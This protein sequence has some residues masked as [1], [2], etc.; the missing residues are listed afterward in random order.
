MLRFTIN[1]ETAQQDAKMEFMTFHHPLIRA[2]TYH[3][4]EHL[5]E[6]HPASHIKLRWNGIMP[7][8]Y[9]WF[10]FVIEISGARPMKDLSLVVL[11]ATP[12]TP[13]V[14]D[15]G[16]ALFNEMVLK[17]E[18]ISPP[19]RGRL[20]FDTAA[21]VVQADETLATRL[22]ARFE[23]MTKYNEALVSNRL[24]SLEESYN[25]TFTK[26][27]ERLERAI[28]ENKKTTYVKGLETSIRNLKATFEDKKAEIESLRKIG[29]S[30]DL[31]G[32]GMVE[33]YS[34]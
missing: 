17:G 30:F 6:L 14:E 34:E 28:S 26:R 10:I 15:E 31:K 11:R 16:N 13:L 32:G 8:F 2:I 4:N 5:D 27:S 33:V 7:G 25:R 22:N 12:V 3:Y 18:T 24:A 29:K 1:S 19:E 20:S 23:Q 21:L 9:A